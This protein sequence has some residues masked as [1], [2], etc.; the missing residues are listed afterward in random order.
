MSTITRAGVY[1]K[2]SLFLGFL[3]L[4]SCSP[5]CFCK[6][7]QVCPT[8]YILQLFVF[9]VRT[10]TRS[11]DFQSKSETLTTENVLPF[12]DE[13]IVV[14]AHKWLQQLDFFALHLEIL[15]YSPGLLSGLIYLRRIDDFSEDNLI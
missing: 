9:Q 1:R 2:V 15:G 10:Y 5:D 4:R 14:L 11:I 8:Y 13:V 3:I 6:V 12:T 7:Q